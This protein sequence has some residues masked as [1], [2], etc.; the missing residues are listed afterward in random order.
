M[1][2]WQGTDHQIVDVGHLQDREGHHQDKVGHQEED[3]LQA[4]QEVH[5]D[6]IVDHHP[7]IHNTE[8]HHQEDQMAHQEEDL[9]QA[10]TQETCSDKAETH[11]KND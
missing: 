4:I 8:A 11:C 2:V 9:H 3:H 7:A 1:R 6:K 5:Q 10:V